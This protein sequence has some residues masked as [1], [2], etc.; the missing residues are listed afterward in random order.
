[1]E[2]LTEY[3]RVGGHV[4]VVP[5]GDADQ[6]MMRLAD[7]EDTGLTPD[8]IKRIKMEI[9]AGCVKAVARAYGLDINRLR[10]MAAADRD[11]RVIVTDAPPADNKP[12]GLRKKYRV[13]KAKDNVPVEGCF[14]LRPEKDPAAIGDSGRV[15]I[16]PCKPGTPV[17]MTFCGEVWCEDGRRG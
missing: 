13:Y 1:M 6:A 8:E 11:G 2:R 15:V 3:E 4:H 7:Y 12:Y 16:L 17:Y 9:E 14:V 5:T 10:E